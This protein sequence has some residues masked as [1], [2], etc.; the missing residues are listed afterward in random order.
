[1]CDDVAQLGARRP[2]QCGMPLLDS[3]PLPLTQLR[4]LTG[5]E[6]TRLKNASISNTA[7]L[8]DKTRTAY[9]EKKLA[10]ATGISASR[11]REAVNRADLVR[12]EGIGPAQADLFENAGVNSLKELSQRNPASLHQS[13]VQYA[14]SRPELGFRAPSADQVKALVAKAASVFG[15][16]PVSNAADAQKLGAQRMHEYVDKVLFGT[17][18]EGDQFRKHVLSNWLPARWPELQ[19]KLHDDVK[20]YFADPN[21]NAHETATAYA[22]EGPWLGFYTELAVKKTGGIERLF[23]E[24][25]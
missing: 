22:W 14:A 24:I 25:D 13:L 2:R 12:L 16:S 18:P 11:M 7:Q 17:H 23:V 4:G 8:L 15:T 9:A 21:T 1:V 5:A 10:A 19:K 20:N 3:N 6:V